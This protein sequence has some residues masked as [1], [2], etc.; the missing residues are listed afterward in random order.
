MVAL[1]DRRLVPDQDPRPVEARQQAVVHQVVGARHVRAQVLQVARR[2]GPCPRPVRAAP[3]P[4]MSSW[5]DAPRSWMRRLL[6]HR[7]PLLHLHRAQ[8]DPAALALHHPS[9]LA[10]RDRGRSR[11]A[12]RSGDH[13]SGA[14]TGSDELQR[15]AASRAG[16]GAG[17]C[18]CSRG[19]SA[20]AAAPSSVGAIRRP[21]RRSSSAVQQQLGA[22][23]AR[24]AAAAHAATSC[25]GP[26][27][28]RA[29]RAPAATGRTIP[30]QFHQPSGRSGFLRPSTI[31]TSSFVPAGPQAAGREREGRV[32]VHVAADA[33]PVQDHRRVAADA[34][35][36]EQ[37]AEAAR[38]GRAL[39]AH[40]VAAHLARIER[41]QRA[42]VE[43][44]RHRACSANRPAPARRGRPPWPAP[45]GPLP[46]GAVSS[47]G[48]S[49]GGAGAAASTRISQP[50]DRVR[51]RGGAPC[52]S[53][54]AGAARAIRAV[55]R[56]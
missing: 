2:S 22:A 16:A 29:R 12:G 31:T 8:A 18:G 44:A 6:R 50:L 46:S 32:R 40:A 41:R 5:I 54:A 10:Q 45:P 48:A 35:E 15:G 34:L 53:A 27:C 20:R 33:A 51:S 13:S 47:G 30:F 56:A 26:G 24:G 11:A 28:A 38:G 49:W 36:A 39:E 43:H 55:T 52:A 42:R 14:G 23:A 21:P 37:P 19:R 25:P 1:P 17:S 9:A 3:E 4:G 7:C